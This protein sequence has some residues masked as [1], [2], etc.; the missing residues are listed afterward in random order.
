MGG[1]GAYSYRWFVDGVE[2]DQTDANPVFE[3]YSPGYHTI[4]LIVSDGED[5]SESVIE[6]AVAIAPLKVYVSKEGSKTFPY[7]TVEKATD[8]VNEAFDTLWLEAGVPTEVVIGEGR[9]MMSGELVCL[10]PITIEGA[11]IDR[12]ILDGSNLDYVH[13]CASIS[14]DDVA[15]KNLTITKYKNNNGGSA[16]FMDKNGLVESVRI[17][18]NC[19]RNSN[20]GGQLSSG[21][22]ISMSAGTVK[23]CIIDS[24]YADSSYGNV[25]GVGVRM[26][27]GLVVDT[28]ICENYRL[29]NQVTGCG[30]YLSGGKL[31][32]CRVV[33]NYNNGT[34][35]GSDDTQGI[36]LHLNGANA[37]VENCYVISNGL[38][39]IN[40]QN[41]KVYNT[42]V[43]GHK[44]THASRSGGIWQRNGALYNCTIAGNTSLDDTKSDLLKTGGTIV[45]TIAEKAAYTAAATDSNNIINTDPFFKK[46]LKLDFHLRRSSPAVDGGQNAIW[47]EVTD[48]TDL[49]GNRRIGLFGL[50]MVDIGCYELQPAVRTLIELK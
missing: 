4:R 16:I 25:Y 18:E 3:S 45:N 17:T 30:A 48:A 44:M 2:T 26:S 28:E 41:G 35:N 32:R 13:R 27:G 39:G 34:G 50:R 47:D 36:G 33:K 9:Y 20:G 10:T 7:D 5:T 37:I 43:A 46:P 42:L 49:D 19:A 12:T 11:G 8:S 6:N 15:I 22:G 38:S 29:R 23:D 40:L 21:V 24:N 31:L 14:A 1:T